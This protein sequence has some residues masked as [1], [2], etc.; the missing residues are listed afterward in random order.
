M[1]QFFYKSRQTAVGAMLLALFLLIIIPEIARAKLKSAIGGMFLPAIGISSAGQNA[2]GLIPEES[3]APSQNQV[4]NNGLK[5][6]LE[7]EN[8]QLRSENLRLREALEWE[9]RVPWE[10]KLARVIGSDSFNWWRRLKLNL[11]SLHGLKV[12]QPVIS[13]EGYLVGKITEV[14]LKTSW[15][16]LLGDPNC[17]FSALIKSSRQQGGIVS[18]RQFNSN[19]RVVE[20]TYLP[21]DIE[22]R[23]GQT[24]VTSGLGG[25][26]PKEIPVG[27]VEDSWISRNG[28]YLEANIKIFSD[29][30]RLEEVRVL[31]KF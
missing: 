11:G 29:L 23:P 30:T 8:I 4:I 18:P 13:V 15:A 20:L 5:T 17:R 26:F 28:L 25:A 3:S 2:L 31:T 12:N 14:G 27:L 16:V 19:Y 9:L 1:K 21:N 24:V 6:D 7:L 10:S 22:I